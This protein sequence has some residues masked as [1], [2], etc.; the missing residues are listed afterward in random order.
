MKKKIRIIIILLLFYSCG[1]PSYIIENKIR[2][3]SKQDIQMHYFSTGIE[4]EIISIHADSAWSIVGE[5]NYVAQEN[6]FLTDS[7]I[8]E[9]GDSVFITHRNPNRYSSDIIRNIM[10]D[11]N[12]TEFI[13]GNYYRYEY[14]FTDADYQEALAANAK[15]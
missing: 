5:M 6:P 10:I 1:D 4:S 13:N 8:I 9:Y 15:K 11:S 12:W 7:V 3:K 14:T 2:N